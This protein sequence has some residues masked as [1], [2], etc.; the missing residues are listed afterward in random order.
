MAVALR[1]LPGQP[2]HRS[3]RTPP[4]S[5]ARAAGRSARARQAPTDATYRRR[6]A[7]VGLLV[8]GVV[9]SAGLVAGNVLTGPGGV[10][11]SAAGAATAPLERTVRARPGDSLW[12][13]AEVFHGDVSVSRYVEAL[14][15]AN[16][17]TRIEAG[18]LVR[19]P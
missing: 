3:L 14:I 11:A 17:G 10:P 1:S 5:V 12:S 4:R 18:Q 16:G 13:I 6:R 15:S 19:L 9:G 8:A 7:V 2:A